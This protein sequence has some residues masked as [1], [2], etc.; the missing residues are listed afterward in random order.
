M[1]KKL[2][3]P[4]KTGKDIPEE[5]S[6]LQQRILDFLKEHVIKIAGFCIIILLIFSGFWIFK[7]THKKKEEKASL[8]FF[9][10][11]QLYLNDL[12]DKNGSFERTGG[13]FKEITE[14]YPN[15]GS[16]VLSFFYMG[17]CQY[18]LKEYDNA[19]FSYNEFLKAIQNKEVWKPFINLVYDSLG[20]CYEAKNEYENAL[21]NFKKT[22]DNKNFSLKE[23]GYLNVG[24]CYELLEQ[25]EKARKIYRE[26]K[27]KY[28]DSVYLSF[29]NRKINSLH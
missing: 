5:I 21:E 24:R 25:K 15:A 3:I 12:N 6:T 9:K 17:N 1:P 22:I 4:R 2:R 20:Y 13:L 19:I 29:I 26:F 27:E 14:K 18:E 23:S 7:Y 11:K 10:A 16:G 8:L 28:P